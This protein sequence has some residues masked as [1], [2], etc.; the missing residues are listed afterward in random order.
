VS[1][2]LSNAQSDHPKPTSA[3]SVA[4]WWLAVDNKPEGPHTTAYIAVLLE[5]GRIDPS[6]LICPVGGETW[7]PLA[8]QAEFA[9]LSAE[10][11]KFGTPPPIPAARDGLQSST[12][13]F[14]AR[15]TNPRL[16][17]MANWICVYCIL[18]YPT[19][20]AIEL[21]LTIGGPLNSAADLR[22]NSPL[23]FHAVAFDVITWGTEGALAVAL[24][25]GG[26]LLR[27]LQRKGV[28]LLKV[29][30]TVHLV[31]CAS[32]LL[33]GLYLDALKTITDSSLP[34]EEV[35]T[36]GSA[37]A[38]LL[39]VLSAIAGL[40]F[41]VVALVWLFRHDHELPLLDCSADLQPME[42][43]V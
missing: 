16:P 11:S 27:R 2:S 13:E 21:L 9:G 30:L 14:L 34:F 35:W 31:W 32:V 4:R 22:P 23:V 25:F 42:E 29:V 40:V 5:E 17:R 1:D 38:F 7:R 12:H 6:T 20:M 28:V 18:V 15:F 19:L 43:P 39:L 36:A 26:L 24:V 10:Q 3:D 8:D 37:F 33:I 41:E